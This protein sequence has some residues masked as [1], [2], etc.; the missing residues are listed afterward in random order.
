MPDVLTALL[1]HVRIEASL[2]GRVELGA[3]W[4][5]RV[6][7]RELVLLHHL[8]EGEMWLELDG[9]EIHV[10]R[11]DLLLLP[12]GVPHCLRH[13]PGAPVED[14]GRWLAPPAPG[15]QAVRRRLG[16]DGAKT[17][18]LCAAM[19]LVGAGRSLLL[20][21][22]PSVV[23]L[24]GGAGEPV[25][26]LGRLLDGIRD[27]VHVRRP[28]AP[29]M[30]ARFAEL[31]LLQAIR[32]EIER[33][34]PPGSFRAALADERVARALDALYL[35]PERA[36]TVASLARQ[37]G[38]SRSG[39]AHAFREQ[40]G[41][42]PLRHLMRWRMELAKEKLRGHPELALA[43]VASS[44]GYR[45]QA[46]FSVAFRREVGVPPGAYRADPTTDNPTRVGPVP[47]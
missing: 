28:G 25:P 18:V 13:R 42:S 44:V 10:G 6:G 31:L 37:A 11:G 26:G 5:A 40:V 9:R 17:V 2:F 36:W 29:V 19:S 16:G 46:A 1:R 20:R 30:A 8:L 39:F 43:E 41:E 24:D 47:G 33:P 38:M 14:E 3:P 34:A 32:A 23:L 21:A 12:H 45:D 35:A 7:R 22:L 4:G 15:V 27:E